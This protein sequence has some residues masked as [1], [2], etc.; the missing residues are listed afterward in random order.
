MIPRVWQAETVPSTDSGTDQA[1]FESHIAV[2][3]DSNANYLLLV[4]HDQMCLSSAL[5]DKAEASS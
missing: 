3:L 4:R 5:K 1:G 2:S